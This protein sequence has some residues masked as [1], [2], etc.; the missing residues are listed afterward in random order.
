MNDLQKKYTKYFIILLLCIFA[1][2]TCIAQIEG[3]AYYSKLDSVTKTGFYKIPITPAIT[4]HVKTNYADVR[5]INSNYKWVPH[6]YYSTANNNTNKDTIIQVEYTTNTQKNNTV[7]IINVTQEINNFM[8]Q[9]SNTD[10]QR[11]AIV[12]GSNDG[13]N[14]YAINDS[15]LLQPKQ[16]DNTTKA[17]VPIYFAKNKYSNYK[18]IINNGNKNAFAIISIS[19]LINHSKQQ[20]AATPTTVNPACIFTQKDSAQQSVIKIIQHQPYHF[21]EIK[22][23]VSAIKYFN[24]SVDVYI[25]KNENQTLQQS[26]Y[27][28]SN[29]ISNSKFI[30][31]QTPITK[32][33]CIFIVVYNNDNL[34]LVFSNISTSIQQQYLVAYVEAGNEYS[35]IIGNDDAQLP[36]YDVSLAYPAF[37][38]SMNIL[39]PKQIIA[40]PVMTATQIVQKNYSLLMWCAII[41]A[42]LVLLFVTKKLITE[43]SKKINNDSI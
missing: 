41:I 40:F 27:L 12:S 30:N 17:I 3:Y 33:E 4:A 35:L 1:N 6:Q 31:I 28:Q 22:L 43:V 25:A 42:L 13:I 24:R 15:M 38:D 21:S 39:L 11:Y 29:T 19:T 23:E 36:N 9:I 10:V 2:Y 8:L 34:P 5:I 20:I 32:A 14:W 26:Q 7:L 18:I 37:T 16:T